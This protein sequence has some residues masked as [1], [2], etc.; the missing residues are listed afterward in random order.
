MIISLKQTETIFA[1]QSHN[2]FIHRFF[3]VRRRCCRL[4]AAAQ[5]ST[6]RKKE[7]VSERTKELTKET[8]DRERMPKKLNCSLSHPSI[9]IVGETPPP[10]SIFNIS[11]KL[12]CA[13]RAETFLL[14]YFPSRALTTRKNYNKTALS[15]DVSSHRAQPSFAPLSMR[16]LNTQNF[17]N[18]PSLLC[19]LLLD[20]PTMKNIYTY[21]YNTQ[22]S[23]FFAIANAKA[24]TTRIFAG[25]NQVCFTFFSF[26]V[27]LLPFAAYSASPPCHLL[28]HSVFGLFAETHYSSA[29]CGDADLPC[30]ASPLP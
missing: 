27:F 12:C 1:A 9:L 2:R 22:L 11:N 16:T 10:V 4:A 29:G 3:A 6:F 26:P 18:P 15:N 8:K 28:F 5:Q 30:P 17:K 25:K 23:Y 21:V 20:G 19:S 13:C 7:R 24:K 14:L